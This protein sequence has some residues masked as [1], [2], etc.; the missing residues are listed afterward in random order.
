MALTT[1]SFPQDPGRT[2]IDKCKQKQIKNIRNYTG[3]GDMC[4]RNCRVI[5]ACIIVFRYAITFTVSKSIKNLTGGFM[6]NRKIISI[7]LFIAFM[8]FPIY[9]SAA[10]GVASNNVDL[11]LACHVDK[12]SA[13]KLMNKEILPLYINGSEFKK[14]IHG[15]TGCSGCHPDITMDNHPVSKRI[16]SKSEYSRNLS[17]NCS[18]C[19]TPEQ[20]RKRQPIHSTLAAKGTCIECHG[21]HYI[22]GI[23]AA[24]VGVKE[25]VYCITCHSNRLSMSMKNGENL[26]VY[27]DASV[28]GNSVHGKLQCTDCHKGFSKTIHPVRSF[29]SRR[30]YS[31]AASEGCWKCHDKVYKEYEVSVH[32]DMLKGGNQKAP[33]CSDCH[34]DHSVASAKKDKNI[35]IASCNKCHSDMNSSYTASMHGKARLKGDEKAPG[36]SSCH[37][38]HKVESTAMTTKIKDGCLQCHKGTDKVHNKWLSNSPIALP[39]FSQAHFDVVSCAACHASPAAKRGVYLI[40]YDRRTGKPLPEGELLKVLE[41]DSAGL[42]EK[43]DTNGDGGIDPKELWNVFALLFKKGYITVFNGKMDVRSA[44]DAHQIGPK[45]EAIKDCAKCHVPNAELFKDVFVVIKKEDGKPVLINAKREILTSVMSIL[46]MSK[47]YVLGS[48]SIELFDILFIVALIGGIAVPIGHISIRILF[49][50]IRSLRR[51]GKGGKK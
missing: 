32:L 45:A 42:S 3:K 19:H 15:K 41:T 44:A 48:T 18:I 30:D 5:H 36:C 12:T 40:L 37:Q 4:Q 47:F 14:S 51:M 50:P 22:K 9:V 34:G 21:S 8:I 38:A 7:F 1:Q 31:I 13:K 11:C 17:R 6:D 16:K 33:T 2:G 23:A 10:K 39:T 27:V 29:S 26:S 46:P 28:I 20:L 49:S 35:G 24:K 25:N 43:L